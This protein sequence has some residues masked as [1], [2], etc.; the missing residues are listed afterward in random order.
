LRRDQM[1]R[2]LAGTG[3]RAREAV[4][5]LSCAIGIACA[6][7]VAG[8]GGGDDTESESSLST[9]RPIVDASTEA[10]DVAS[11]VLPTEA[12]DDEGGSDAEEATANPSV[13]AGVASATFASGGIALGPAGCGGAAVT[14]MFSISNG[15]T[16]ALSVTAATTGSAFSVS[17]SSLSVAAS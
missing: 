4:I 2:R 14:S 17:P 15:G 1:A 10:S 8:C 11:E 13:D 3:A 9:G 12:A 7:M 16:A 6:S 5:R